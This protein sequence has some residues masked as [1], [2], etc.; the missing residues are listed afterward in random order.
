MMSAVTDGNTSD[1]PTAN[2]AGNNT[3]TVRRPKLPWILVFILFLLL[4]Y[5]L[6]RGDG[7]SN[8]RKDL[9]LDERID[10]AVEN[11]EWCINLEPD[12]K[13]D[14]KDSYGRFGFSKATWKELTSPTKMDRPDLYELLPYEPLVPLKDQREVAHYLVEEYIPLHGESLS[15][16]WGPECASNA[17][18]FAD[19][20]LQLTW[21]KA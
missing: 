11:L 13:N 8:G 9:P 15:T 20:R 18:D 12:M 19:I 5:T 3:T 4:A 1:D 10:L 14:A 7:D 2:A 6:F 17:Q 16:Y 21:A